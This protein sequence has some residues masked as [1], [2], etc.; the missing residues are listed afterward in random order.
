M[1]DT[2]VACCYADAAEKLFGQ[3]ARWSHI[4]NTGHAAMYV[5][6]CNVPPQI[7]CTGLPSMP[8]HTLSLD[9]GRVICGRWD[10]MVVVPGTAGPRGEAARLPHVCPMAPGYGLPPILIY[11]GSVMVI[12]IALEKWGQEARCLP[13][14]G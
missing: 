4:C 1:L 11:N 8:S 7:T 9:V 14:I 3:C 5:L 13:N 2:N 10:C 12:T 6:S